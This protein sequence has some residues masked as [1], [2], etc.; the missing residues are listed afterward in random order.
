MITMTHSSSCLAPQHKH[1][2]P[3]FGTRAKQC[4]EIC[5]F[6]NAQN[7]LRRVAASKIFSL[8]AVE[9]CSSSV[10][11][12]FRASSLTSLCVFAVA[13]VA[14]R[15]SHTERRIEDEFHFHEFEFRIQPKITK[16]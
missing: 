13:R 5:V 11:Q 14:A 16:I 6:R 8:D 1:H 2:A 9:R 15:R 3:V 10:M 12:N 4:Y 7:I